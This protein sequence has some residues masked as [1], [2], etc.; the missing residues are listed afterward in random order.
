MN[1]VCDNGN[2]QGQ[3]YLICNACAIE[4]CAEGGC[5]YEV[6]IAALAQ[7]EERRFGNSVWEPAVM[8]ML[9]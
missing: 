6:R 9:F 1:S 2:F 3:A 5:E 4:S 8:N 7:A